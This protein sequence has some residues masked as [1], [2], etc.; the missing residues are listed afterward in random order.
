MTHLTFDR[1]KDQK[2]LKDGWV[3]AYKRDDH[4]QIVSYK[5]QLVAKGFDP[6]YGIPGRKF[7]QIMGPESKNIH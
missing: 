5:A 4:N 7:P 2:V 6:K 1:P 3:L